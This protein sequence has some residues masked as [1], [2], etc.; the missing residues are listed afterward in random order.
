[1]RQ[2]NLG[3]PPELAPLPSRNS[4]ASPADISQFT[5]LNPQFKSSREVLQEQWR[6]ECASKKQFLCNFMLSTQAFKD[7]K[8]NFTHLN[9]Y[10][11]LPIEK[12]EH[13]P[14]ETEIL[15]LFEKVV[16]K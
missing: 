7:I 6:K 14:K 3:S 16:S 2:T 11:K 4:A 10:F 5:Q 9:N 8:V 15:E 12:F 1:M 13:W